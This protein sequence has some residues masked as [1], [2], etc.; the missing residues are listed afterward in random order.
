MKKVFFTGIIAGI[1]FITAY[2]QTD[3][4]TPT[5]TETITGTITETETQ[6]ITETETQT[7]TS[8]ITQ[9]ITDTITHTETQ[10]ITGTI[11]QTITETETQTI[12]NTTTET[13]TYSVTFTITQT[14][15][16]TNTET[17][18]STI[19][20][21][22]TIT[23]TQT[24]TLT[25]T[26]THT[27]TVTETITITIT[28]T[29][30]EFFTP[31]ITPTSTEITTGEGNALISPSQVAAGTSGNTMTIEYTAGPTTWISGMLKIIIPSGW[32]PPS[33]N[34]TDPGFYTVSVLNGELEGDSKSGNT[35][36]VYVSNLIGNTGKI[37]IV[38]GSK[39]FGGPGATSQSN[40]GIAVFGIMSATYGTSVKPIASQP[41]VNVIE[42]TATPTITLTS[43]PT[44]TITPTSTIT[45]TITLTATPQTGEGIASVNPGIVLAGGTGYTMTIEYTAGP[46][47]WGSGT[48]KIIIPSGWSAPSINSADPGYFTVTVTSGVYDG[49]LKS[50]QAIIVYA[51]SLTA[52]TGKITVIYGSK[53][54][55]G[56][57]ATVQSSPG[58]AKFIVES[59]PDGATTYEIENSPYV[60][61]SYPTATITQTITP[62]FTNTPDETP[63]KPNLLTVQNTADVVTFS[64]NNTSNTDYY[65]I[66]YSSG[67][68]GKFN[69]FPSGWNII[70]TVLPTPT[71]SS[72]IHNDTTGN[73]FS[74]YTIAGVN[75]VGQSKPSLPIAKVKFNFIARPDQSNVYRISL[76]YVNKYTTASSIVADIEGNTYTSS[77]IDKLLL[78]NSFNQT[79]ITYGYS[80]SLSKWVGTDWIVDA[81]TVSSNGI[82]I[83]VISDFQWV[84]AGMDKSTDLV[85]YYNQ[86]KQNSNKR[87]LPFIADYSKASDIVIDI[88]GNTGSGSNLK[89]NKLLLWNPETQVFSVYGYSDSLGKWVGTNFDIFAGD[90][91]NIFLS[92]N[93]SSFTWTPKLINE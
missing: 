79:S 11:T 26:Q 17:I 88:E 31:T 35:I 69:P 30:T 86:D 23:V 77:K 51:S 72:F 15:T 29:Q 19:T 3:T 93:T 65:R 14:H 46:T 12:T 2:A 27:E 18:T 75:G 7:I 28:E 37:T 71:V 54:G 55:G 64:W 1:F 10:T 41:E 8:T 9:T 90:M 45:L 47:T 32:S 39:A 34:S 60:T 89:I 36:N 57:G 6:T 83:N 20:Q 38:Y 25:N 68:K 21:T 76:P 52:N 58:N 59:N 87:C 85:F 74:F 48:L 13:I 40:T 91:I 92:G 16:L 66:Y 44:Q 5:I 82:Y 33:L 49:S 78:W 22:I 61:V 50:G 73:T 70:A 43:S 63:V 56:P 53:T 80:Q 42:P 24:I 81:G 84:V 62:T 4:A 67:S